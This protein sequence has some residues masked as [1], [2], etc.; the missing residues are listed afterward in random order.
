MRLIKED[1]GVPGNHSYSNSTLSD[2]Q[3]NSALKSYVF[4]ISHHNE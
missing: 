4:K 3:N 2:G 1:K